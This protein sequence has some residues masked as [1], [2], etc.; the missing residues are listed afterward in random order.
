MSSAPADAATPP[1]PARR[2]ASA[3]AAAAIAGSPR[4]AL[5]WGGLISLLVSAAL[6]GPLTP[7]PAAAGLDLLSWRVFT[8][9]VE[10]RAPAAPAAPGGTLVLGVSQTYFESAFGQSSPLDRGELA[11]LLEPVAD[12]AR[13]RAADGAPPLVV[14]I[15]FD[16]SPPT[17]A[18]A[19]REP[20]Q[21]RL[22]ATLA[23][24]AADATL[25]VLCPFETRGTE[26]RAVKA[27]W[28]RR[29]LDAS[30]PGPRGTGLWLAAPDLLAQ[31]DAVV[32]HDPTRPTL[33]ALAG[34]A[35][36]GAAMP[37]PDA[38]C[39]ASA[40]APRGRLSK[41]GV[42][43]LDDATL[44]ELD[45]ASGTAL[46]LAATAPRTVFVGGSYALAG[47]EFAL[48]DG[49]RVPGVVL[50]AA[51]AGSVLRPVAQGHRLFEPLF[52]LALA[53]LLQ[54]LV[55]P[56]VARTVAF[57]VPPAVGVPTDPARAPGTFL[58]FASRGQES[59][60]LWLRWLVVM[61]LAPAALA[62]LLFATGTVSWLALGAA[63]Y[64]IDFGTVSLAVFAKTA[65]SV[66]QRVQARGTRA[67]APDAVAASPASSAVAP[68]DATRARRGLAAGVAVRATI[69][70]YGLVSLLW[71]ALR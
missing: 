13:R 58:L 56:L 12:A 26:A 35:R 9:L 34:R 65:A 62:A 49:R 29:V 7:G 50:H 39:A 59:P 18:G 20:G 6:K 55:A 24:I 28:A 43:A 52:G 69:L 31:G 53:V 11:R 3:R 46:Y 60:E 17:R 16:L 68:H 30:P 2:S 8:A 54:P 5:L 23:A 57:L 36:A 64:W 10:P 40:Q 14:A 71:K 47:D 38:A 67:L 19:D 61:T 44:V 37:A 21:R 27:A 63:D 15:D 45:G 1:R 66:F 4:L 22:E 32:H 48:A 51:V 70:G 33:G 25:V 41:I 42:H